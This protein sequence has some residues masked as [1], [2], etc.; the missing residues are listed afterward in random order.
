MKYP[1]I[2]GREMEISTLERLYKSKKSEFVAIYGRRRIGK[3]YLVSEVYGSKIVFS[4]VGT[5]VK[6][7]DKNYE[8]YRKLQLD[9]FYDSLILSGL[10]AATTERPTCWREAFLLLRRLLEGIRSRRKVILIDELPWLAG[11]QSSEMISELGYF[12]NSWADSQRNIILVVCGSATSWMLDNVIRDYGG[13]HGRLTETIKLAPF[14]LAECQKYYRRNGFRLSRYEMCICYMALGGVPFYLDKLRN[15]Q[16]ITE[17]IDRI[18]F[19]DEKIHQEFLDVFAGLYASKERYVDIVKVLGSQFYGMTQKEI[20]TAI[21]VKTGGTLTKLLE[22]LMESGIIRAYPRYGKERVETVYQLID[23]FSLFY[24]RFIQGKQAKKGIWNSIH[25]TPTF[26]TWAGD[27]FEL[28]CVEHLPQIQDTL[29]IASINRNYCWSGKSPDGKG[30]QI[31]LLLESK[32]DRTDYLCEMKFTGGKYAI[33]KTD[34]EDF[35]NKIEA[36]AA[37]KMHN[38]THSIQLVM[39]TTMGVARGEHASIVNQSV[40]LDNSFADRLTQIL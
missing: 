39:I 21:D 34:E 31:D 10:D 25:G 15:S 23:F 12:W 36:F 11:P 37:S 26:Y 4:A 32:A 6:D 33:T 30:A 28:L 17:N 14:T 2:I 27:T 29:R 38:K 35:L 22:N 24:L 7:G 13:L 8:T 3:S 19:A 40:V 16:T 20:S 18:F 1:N 5:Y 9:H